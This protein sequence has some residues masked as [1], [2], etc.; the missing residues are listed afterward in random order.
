MNLLHQGR[1]HERSPDLYIE[2]VKM[3]IS[4]FT[5]SIWMLSVSMHSWAT[6]HTTRYLETAVLA[7]T[8]NQ[9]R[10]LETFNPSWDLS[11]SVFGYYTLDLNWESGLVWPPVEAELVFG[12]AM[13][14]TVPFKTECMWFRGHIRLCIQPRQCCG[15]V[16]IKRCHVLAIWLN[17][18]LFRFAAIECEAFHISV[19]SY[20][21]T[22]FISCFRSIHFPN[23][24]NQSIRV[25]LLR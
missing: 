19:S 2:E 4:S 23:D 5:T 16:Y 22:N 12:G 15:Y 11:C 25:R 17:I 8:G 13:P 7:A 14:P 10:P 9:V 18:S 20:R 1:Q 6:G 24:C 3:L 21:L